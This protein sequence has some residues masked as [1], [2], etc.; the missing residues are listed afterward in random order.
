VPQPEQVSFMS[1]LFA[2]M[3]RVRNAEA[4]RDEI[5]MP[6]SVLSLSLYLSLGQDMIAVTVNKV[7]AQ[8]GRYE[9]SVY[10]SHW[11][12]HEM[13]ELSACKHD[14][15]HYALRACLTSFFS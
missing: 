8:R 10:V 1:S 5:K 14:G 9:L 2:T 11:T 4:S 15:V 7:R 12:L 6:R 13:M 3:N